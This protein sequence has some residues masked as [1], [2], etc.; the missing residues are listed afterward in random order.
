MWIGNYNFFDYKYNIV[1]YNGQDYMSPI[2]FIMC[3]IGIAVIIALLIIFRKTKKETSKKLFLILAIVMT[4]MYV[5]KTTWESVY[6][7]Q[8]DGK[9]NIW[10][11][12]F[13]TCSLLM[14]CLF[15]AGLARKDS[16]LERFAASFLAT[17]GFAGG[18]ANMIFL[19]GLNYYPMFSF[20]G[21]Y[22]YFW[23][24]VMIFVALYIVVTKFIEFKWMDIV[25]SMVPMVAVSVVVIPLNYIKGLDFML[26]NGAGGV[27]LIEGLAGKLI[28]A[29][30]R[31][32]ATL[33]MLA[34]YM[35]FSG[36]MVSIFIGIYKLIGIAQSKKEQVSI[37]QA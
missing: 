10:I 13:D 4:S 8:R 25:Y 33:L 7:I 5:F 36:V 27:P 2:Q 1:G 6:D 30:L 32:L 23:H 15:I 3:G 28:E 35:A 17:I 11:L 31:P 22:S 16:L 19:R 12:P 34:V 37:E 29:G 21:L 24:L 20:G 9:F 26:I 14:P 18:V